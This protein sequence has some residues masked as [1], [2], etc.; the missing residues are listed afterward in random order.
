MEA[1]E[2]EQI[3]QHF[4][5]TGRRNYHLLQRR[6]IERLHERLIIEF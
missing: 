4:H 5:H 1:E 2:S 3:G 6:G